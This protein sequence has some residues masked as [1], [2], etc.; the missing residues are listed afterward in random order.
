MSRGKGAAKKRKKNDTTISSESDSDDQDVV[1]EPDDEQE[2][3]LK[4]VDKKMNS[5]I[6]RFEKLLTTKDSIIEDLK[7]EL[8]NLKKRVVLLEEKCEDSE[9]KER[10]FSVIVSG[11]ELPPVREGVDSN[12]QF[13]SL[14]K[15][16]VGV[17][18]K[19]SDIL[20]S[21]RIGRKSET[22][23]DNRKL[24]VKFNCQDMKNDLIKACKGV[25][26]KNLFINENLT[27][28]RTSTL[29]GLRQARKKHPNIVAGC[30]SYNG[31]VYVWV[32]P[33]KPNTPDSKNTKIFVNSRD[34]FIDFCLKTL[35]CSST[36]LI[37]N[38]P[39]V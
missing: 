2:K 31:R 30:G 11:S 13:I 19:S 33:P 9:T 17:S 38:W 35:N 24:L 39:N 20:V 26:P 18:L 27:P 34:K 25:K 15:D 14:I 8:V 4:L 6:N 37:K 29:Y 10:Q 21:Q 22:E 23:T 3:L 12:K 1:L 32:K 28:T 7:Q 5:V 36:D 16:K